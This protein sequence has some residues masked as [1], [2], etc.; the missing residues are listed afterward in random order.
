M[1]RV[2]DVLLLGEDQI[3]KFV[4]PFKDKPGLYWL[5]KNVL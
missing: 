5:K 1:E 4:L 2:A 3:K